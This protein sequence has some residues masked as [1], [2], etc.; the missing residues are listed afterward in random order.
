[1]NMMGYEL[2]TTS[3][4]VLLPYTALGTIRIFCYQP[5]QAV[6]NELM[7]VTLFDIKVNLVIKA[8]HE[9]TEITIKEFLLKMKFYSIFIG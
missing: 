9:R 8:C 5:E 2:V 6:V 1:M 4:T 7:D 3:Y